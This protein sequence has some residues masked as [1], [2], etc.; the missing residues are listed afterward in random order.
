MSL[1]FV[2]TTIVPTL[3][4]AKAVDITVLNVAHLT[5]VTDFMVICTGTS[6]PHVRSLANHLI[7][8]AKASGIKP[9]GCE[10]EEEG[11]WVLVD[12][13]D[14]VVQIMQAETRA[15]YDLEKLWHVTETARQERD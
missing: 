7:E 11:E 13:G 10:G 3:D 8:R 4:E 2:N 12:L 5:D 15:F 1:E 6:R 9:L 14:V